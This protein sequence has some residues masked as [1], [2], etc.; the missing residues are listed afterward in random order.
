MQN[1]IIHLNFATFSRP[2]ACYLIIFH[3]PRET[4]N[5]KTSYRQGGSSTTNY[6][7]FFCT[8]PPTPIGADVGVTVLAVLN[9]MR[10]LK[11]PR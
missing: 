5:E 6:Q 2:K 11:N 9:A 7:Y 3:K 4:Q 10:A 8:S 1:Y